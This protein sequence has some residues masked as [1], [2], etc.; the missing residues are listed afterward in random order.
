L[1]TETAEAAMSDHDKTR[2]QTKAYVLEILKRHYGPDKAIDDRIVEQSVDMLIELMPRPNKQTSDA[3]I[4]P[5]RR[6]V[7]E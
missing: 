4:L 1:E 3:T 2:A 6:K 5:F 7:T